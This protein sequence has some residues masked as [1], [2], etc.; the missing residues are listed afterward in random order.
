[1]GIAG[2]RPANRRDAGPAS[3]DSARQAG[4]AKWLGQILGGPIFV[5]AL[6]VCVG[7]LAAQTGAGDAI[8]ESG[9]LELARG[10]SVSLGRD[11]D[12]AS[13]IAGPLHRNLGLA[14]GDRLEV[15]SEA[16]RIGHA[17]VYAIRQTVNGL[18]LEYRESRL[19]L[20]GERRPV[21]LLGR[22]SPS[23]RAPPLQP[24]LDL[25]RASAAADVS[26]VY[27]A[28]GR[29]VYWPDGSGMRLSYRIEGVFGGGQSP[30]ERVYVDAHSGAVLERLPLMHTGLDRRV[31]DWHSICQVLLANGLDPFSS[32]LQSP[33]AQQ[34]VVHAR[35][36]EPHRIEGS[37]V[38]G[39]H[40]VDRAFDMLGDFH[41]YLLSVLQMDSID[42]AGQ[43]LHAV[44]NLRFHARSGDSPQCFGDE[45]QAFWHDG[46]NFIGLSRPSLDYPE[47]VGHELGH[48]LV[49]SGSGLI[50]QNQP[51]ALNE[52][53]ADA[54]GVGFRAWRAG[55][56]DLDAS[57]PED[58]WTLRFP[59]GVARDMR[60]PKSV[61]SRYPDHFSDYVRTPDDHG[62]VHVNSSIINQ[63][64]YLLAEGGR[65][66]NRS[67]GPEVPGVGMAKA[68]E[69]YGH[70]ASALL[71]PNA[72][73]RDARG[74]LAQ[75]AELLYGESS[76]EWVATHL[77]MDA[78]GIPGY[79]TR[80]VPAEP[81]PAPE[82]DPEPVP[83]NAPGPVT[84]PEPPRSSDPERQ[85]QSGPPMPAA[86][87]PP[88]TLRTTPAL[89][90]AA[91][92][93]AIVFLAVAFLRANRIPAGGPQSD[94]DLN[95]GNVGS[96]LKSS[97]AVSPEFAV[98]PLVTLTPTDGSAGIDLR[99]DLLG[100][101]EGI[102]IGR[103]AEL[104][105]VQ[106]R[107]PKVSRRHLRLC[108]ASGGILVEDL[109]SSMGTQ[110]DG[111]GLEPFRPAELQS[112][113]AVRIGS[114]LF[115]LRLR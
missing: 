8:G 34:L 93:L 60:S 95:S 12:V 5:V 59:G 6:S 112:G 114:H 66:P 84:R 18:P 47:V 107:D 24:T 39:H 82:S 14:A 25:S 55:G 86:S 15:A 22:H 26:D 81:E 44:V 46:L 108:A 61:H 33:E 27:E 48:G 78:V 41:R 100:S 79:W 10:D 38:A 30:F 13:W 88:A 75:A 62:G 49:S 40:S 90:L 20:D 71:F 87:D 101:R 56:G 9:W 69:I 45:F 3:L 99:R 28:T 106:I 70:A 97:D 103:D 19:V 11:S 63:A 85:P 111:E 109:N 51:G 102:V 32:F 31:Y 67:V 58:V 113:Q 7:S 92:G 72:T 50:Y 94:S 57:L 54:I 37:G 76:R 35:L 105:H 1:M 104:C 36:G 110:I 21:S 16:R 17:T 96:G 29:L 74:A 115:H 73:F 77:A 43:T 23:P 4:R 2:I 64:F 42:D 83:A 68:L 91:I 80:P 65:H 53:L 52:A 98:P 89:A